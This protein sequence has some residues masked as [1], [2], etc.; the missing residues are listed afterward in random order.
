[1]NKARLSVEKVYNR[2]NP[3]DILVQPRTR[4]NEVNQDELDILRTEYAQLDSQTTLA[5]R[6]ARAVTVVLM[7]VVLTVLNGYYFF[8]SEKQLFGSAVRLA[9]YLAAVLVAL[10]LAR[11]LS[12]DPWRAEVIP[13]VAIVTVIAI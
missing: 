5:Q 8:R 2:Y 12:F 1:R 6:T 7:L 9:I 4:I 11:F 13:L 3:R 10:A